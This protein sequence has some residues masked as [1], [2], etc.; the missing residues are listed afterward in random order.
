MGKENDIGFQSPIAPSYSNPYGQQQPAP[1][2]LAEPIKV[3]P[4][5]LSGS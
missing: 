5:N 4:R 3:E 2:T 1:Y